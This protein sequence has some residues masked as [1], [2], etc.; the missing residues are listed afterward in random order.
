MKDSAQGRL[1][2]L[3]MVIVL[4]GVSGCGRLPL[5]S[6]TASGPKSVAGDIVIAIRAHEEQAQVY[7]DKGMLPEALIEWKIL[8]TIR[9]DAA[10]YAENIRRLEQRIQDAA[11]KHLRA[12][13]KALEN[14][15]I[16]AA[17]LEFMKSLAYDPRQSTP[18]TYLEE[19]ERRAILSIQTA[20]YERIKRR[21]AGE[22]LAVQ[23]AAAQ[24]DE[25]EFYYLEQ[26]VRLFR[27]GEL[28][29]S[30]VEI[31]KFLNSY[32]GDPLARQ[33]VLDAYLGI[34]MEKIASGK[35]DVALVSLEKSKN[36]AAEDDPRPAAYIR[37][38][39][40]SL[41][42]DYYEKGQR[43]FRRDIDRAIEYWQRSVEY[44]PEHAGAQMRLSTAM[45]IKR[46]LGTL[47]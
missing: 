32:P 35:L 17:K 2:V 31:E 40:K 5:K 43:V 46:K 4:W 15:K 3:G 6:S 18:K 9:P 44:D 19:M 39:K 21:R 30:I 16:R 24:I 29:N 37:R 11:Q 23:V 20:K 38:I 1:L 45:K 7:A 34:A 36:Y 14:G 28:R 33:Y 42:E 41:A 47:N 12:G 27:D 26:G 13:V 8:A 22:K 10:P 25:Q